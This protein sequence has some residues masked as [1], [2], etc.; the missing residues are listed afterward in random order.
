MTVPV[1]PYIRACPQAS[2]GEELCPPEE[3]FLPYHK[4]TPPPDMEEEVIIEAW[5]LLKNEE[6]GGLLPLPTFPLTRKL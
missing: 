6:E 2:V 3:V 5:H 1:L 4:K